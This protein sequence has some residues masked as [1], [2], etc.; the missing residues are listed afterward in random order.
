MVDIRLMQAAV[1][2][3][4]ELHFLRA[5]HRLN[6]TQ[7]TLSKQIA[8]LEERLG[9]PLFERSTQSVTVTD[10]GAAFVE[11][12]RI[13]LAAAE[14]AVHSS[15]AAAFGSEA[16]L[17][18]GKTPYADPYITA[19]I[20]SVRLPLFTNLH[21]R[22]SSHYSNESLKLLRS[23][24]LDLAVVMGLQDYVGVTASKLSEEPFFVALCSSD[25]LCAKR[26]LTLADLT[27]RPWALLERNVNHSVYD[28][29]QK[30][31]AEDGA[32]PTE[33]QH[34]LQAEEAAALILQNDSVALLP[35]FAAWRISDGIITLRPLKDERLIL[36]TFL[37][38][39][40][41][42]HSRLVAEFVKAIARRLSRSPKQ[43][44][45]ALVS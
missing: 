6:I 14:R 28:R 40:L 13:A 32:H 3:A 43:G 30:T 34:I 27:G 11:H 39:R 10:A 17:S 31:M 23:G 20:L 2:V 9:Y 29:L 41:D 5:A 4:E 12:A 18:V 1:A 45:L 25:P 37:V 36:K 24:E 8:E 38:A 15:R 26:E 16:M 19:A 44:K 21:V 33:V 7:P 42:E 35:K 22:L